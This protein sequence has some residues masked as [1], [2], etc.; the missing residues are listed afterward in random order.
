MMWR[1]KS[2]TFRSLRWQSIGIAS[3]LF[4]GLLAAV[5]LSFAWDFYYTL[6]VPSWY[7]LAAPLGAILL[8]PLLGLAMR[9]AALKLP[10]NPVITFCLLG[11]LE[12][13]PE[14]AIGIYRFDILQIP[15]LQGSTASAIYLFAFFEYVIFWGITLLLAIGLD[16]LYNGLRGDA[17]P[18]EKQ[19]DASG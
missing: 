6:F 17:P 13:I 18:H 16:R 12:S 4:W 3:A 15:I 2:A 1:V 7:R 9:W 5:L 8:Y 14:H 19:G 10:G 11:G